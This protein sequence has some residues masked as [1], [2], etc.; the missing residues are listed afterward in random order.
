MYK[1]PAPFRP[2]EL[3][4]DNDILV[5]ASRRNF[6]RSWDL[7]SNATPQ[8]NKPW[9]HSD[10]ETPKPSSLQPCAISF[11]AGHQKLAVAYVGQPVTIWDLEYDEYYGSCGKMLV[12]GEISKHPVTS[13]SFNP[14][15]DIRL[16][17]VSYLDGQL[18]LLDPFEGEELGSF[19]AN[20]R[21]LTSS[22]NGRLHG[23][24]G[25][26]ET[27]HIY[28]FGT[29]KLLYRIRSSELDIKQL[30][31]SRDNFHFADIRRSQCN[32]WEPA[33]L[34]R[35]TVAGDW[36]EST[37][38]SVIEATTSEDKIRISTM[39][40]HD[41]DQ[42]VI[43]G[44]DN[45]SVCLHDARTGAFLQTLHRHK[46]QVRS[47]TWQGGN[48]VAMSVDMANRIHASILTKGP[49]GWASTEF[50]LQLDCG[51]AIVQLLRSESTNRFI[52]SARESDY[53]WDGNGKQ[54]AARPYLEKQGVRLWIEH[55]LS[56]SH[57]I[58]FEGE[59][60][61]I[62]CWEDCSEVSCRQLAV[63][64]AG[65]QLKSLRRYSSGHKRRMLLELTELNGSSR[66]RG[67]Y[68][69]DAASFKLENEMPAAKRAER[70]KAGFNRLIDMDIPAVQAALP[71]EVN[72]SLSDPVVG[73][74]TTQSYP[75]QQV[76]DPL[77][78]PQLM[79]LSRHV[80]HI[81][82]LSDTGKLVFL[83]T[84]SWVS[85]IDLDGFEKSTPATAPAP[86][87]EAVP[88]PRSTS[89]PIQYSRHFFV[90]HDWYSGTRDIVSAAT[91]RDVFFARNGE[92][93]IIKN[94]MEYY[95]EVT[96]GI[97]V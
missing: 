80:S 35:E 84:N 77:F 29:L 83:D 47:L 2:I 65:L 34:L 28:E 72:S 19:R 41:Q 9:S 7:N 94:G 60:A 11:S 15:P 86:A 61:R 89:P 37:S 13:L 79:A 85:S 70:E 8:A 23:G 32:I 74:E 25:A 6:L 76:T 16:L 95:E 40:L 88:G 54:I 48:H 46:C 12:N 53:L 64:M 69:F 59:I 71:S 20:C 17:A 56:E 49:G 92:I 93:A 87:P 36:G 5:V 68:V 97:S 39:V 42:V 73:E 55:P 3:H 62:L 43:C 96:V 18:T 10:A 57:A 51:H 31:F 75:Q 52:L 21:A 67:L 82:H 78:R 50:P 14:N 63:N 90:P 30:V 58:C 91:A 44:K 24:V 26:C 45:G 33:M 27:I 22:P 4:F 81:I 1:L 66:T 38:M